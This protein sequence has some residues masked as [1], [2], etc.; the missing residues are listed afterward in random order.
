MMY[1]I[2]HLS[3]NTGHTEISEFPMIVDAGSNSGRAIM[4]RLQSF[5]SANTYAKRYALKTR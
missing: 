3:H 1:A 2:C 5:G 4:N